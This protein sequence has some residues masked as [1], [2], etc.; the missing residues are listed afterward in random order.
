MLAG[1][2]VKLERGLSSDGSELCTPPAST[3]PRPSPKWRDEVLLLDE[4]E[5]E[6]IPRGGRPAGDDGALELDFA[7]ACSLRQFA[8]GG[9][10][11][12]GEDHQVWLHVYDLGPVTGR[13]NEVLRGANLGAFHCGVEV[14]G[15]EW[16][17]QG[18][19]DAWDDP[20]LTGL[21]RNEP[22]SHESYIYRE[23]VFL[24]SS[25]CTADEIDQVVD[26]MTEAWPASSYH[27]VTKNCINFAMEFTAKLRVPQEFPDWVGGMADAGKTS[28][29]LPIADYGWSWFKWWSKRWVDKE[30]EQRDLEEMEAEAQVATEYHHRNTV[31]VCMRGVSVQRSRLADEAAAAALQARLAAAEATAKEAAPADARQATAATVA[32]PLSA[33]PPG[34]GRSRS[35]PPRHPKEWEDGNHFKL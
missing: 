14:L 6:R 17:F 24:G 19:Y 1:P 28:A 7:P 34:L 16:S 15:D 2:P 20:T 27:V 32:G 10:S 12:N 25:P 3:P 26:D 9:S 23:S 35:E 11:H 33:A 5:P 21:V 13:L 29:L 22:R 18:Y 31:S 30:D 4:L 8:P